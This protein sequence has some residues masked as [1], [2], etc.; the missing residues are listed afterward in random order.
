MPRAILKELV[1]PGSLQFLLLTLAIGTLLLFRRKDGGRAGRTLITCL[2]IF[3]LIFSIPIFAAP[4]VTAFT[5]S[6]AVQ[7]AADARGAT[8]IV[9]LSA[10]FD[11]YRSRGDALDFTTR[12]EAPRLLEAVRVYRLLDHPWVIVTGGAVDGRMTQA[13]H[14]A[15]TLTGLGVDGD[16]IIEEQRASDT[17]EHAL[18]VP[19]LLKEH[20]IRQFV[21]VTSRQH[22]TRAL[23]VFRKVGWD[24]VPSTAEI[25][26]IRHRLEWVVPAQRVLEAAYAMFYDDAAMA[27]YWVRGWV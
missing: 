9:V 24:P 4:I 10:G 17:R 1:I 8:A 27:Y 19:P 23:A 14:M 22:I 7:T 5:P 26:V 2:V 6:Y 12:E 11:T 13:D 3:Y 15:R 21:L 20:D 25:L 16:R 18:F